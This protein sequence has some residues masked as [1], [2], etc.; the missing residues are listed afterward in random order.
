MTPWRRP[1]PSWRIRRGFPAGGTICL[2]ALLLLAGCALGP[3]HVRPDLALPAQWKHSAVEWKSAEPRDHQPRG[4]W[5][6]LFGDETLNRLEM[7]A[8]QANQNLRAAVARVDR[9][10]AEAR[11]VR[12]QILPDV[13]AGLS[14]ERFRRN[15]SGFGSPRSI[16]QQSYSA[17]LDL[18]Y[19]IDLWGRV[20][21]AFESARA[22]A[23]ATEAAFQTVLLTL[24]GDVA[25][26]YFALR[27][28]DVERKILAETVRLRREGLRLLQDRF[29]AGLTGEL[30]LTRARTE[31]SEAEAEAID[32]ERRRAELEN[33]IALL[34]GRPASD[35][36]L[37]DRPQEA[38]PVP[39]IP[40]ALP[41]DLLERRPDIAEAERGV[42]SANAQIGIAQ[43][44]F[45]PKISLTASG[46][47][48]TPASEDLFSWDSRVWSFGPSVS[49]PLTAVGRNAAHLRA[50]KAR[51]RETV[52]L[53]RQAVLNAVRETE[54]ALAN[55]RFRAE[56]EKAQSRVVESARRAAELAGRR[57]QEGL[58]SYLE[59]IDAER[60]RLAAERIAVRIHSQRL[61]CAVG[62]IKA[63]G[64]GWSPLDFDPADE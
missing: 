41:S 11:V 40:A 55:V 19:E 14:Y 30:D 47:F 49:L 8:V 37:P 39:V 57:H 31:L 43:A 5:W 1:P 21:R 56:Q 26:N 32:L 34:C 23:A 15:L 42:A 60:S 6:E 9:A 29:D 16:T 36:R 28:L 45:F 13:T 20:R 17:P 18:S 4:P 53:Y 48:D 27:A 33:A 62:L 52:A 3:D 44:A 61:I 64:G 10:R 46:G 25:R 38:A 22:D 58:V 50:A 24:T 35:F 59:V 51:H 54:D 12:A 63:L 7:Q 2:A